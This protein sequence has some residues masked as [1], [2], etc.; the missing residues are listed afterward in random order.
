[1]INIFNFNLFR[2][3]RQK[4]EKVFPTTYIG[5]R[6]RSETEYSYQEMLKKDFTERMENKRRQKR[7]GY[8]F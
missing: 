5:N 1:M 7:R 4:D 6:K 3:F 2:I 8:S